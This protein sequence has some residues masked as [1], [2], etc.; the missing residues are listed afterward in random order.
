M[1][2]SRITIIVNC[3]RCQQIVIW[4]IGIDILIQSNWVMIEERMVIR[5]THNMM[6]IG[7]Y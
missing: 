6:I 7:S 5:V 3:D 4:K 2:G 1:V